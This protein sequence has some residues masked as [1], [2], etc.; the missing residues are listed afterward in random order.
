MPNTAMFGPL[1]SVDP[2]INKLSCHVGANAVL[3]QKMKYNIEDFNLENY[4]RPQ[5]LSYDL[6]DAKTNK[7]VL[8][9]G[10][11][12]PRLKLRSIFSIMG[13]LNK[14]LEVPKYN[15]LL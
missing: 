1:I 4:K 6:I 10:E 3:C 14:P 15:F 8:G 11:K 9:I 12:L 2:I 5:K 7:K 13:T